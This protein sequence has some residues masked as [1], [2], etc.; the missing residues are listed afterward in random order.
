[1]A[2]LNSFKIYVF[3]HLFIYARLSKTVD[4]F[5]LS[6]QIEFEKSRTDEKKK[7]KKKL[8]NE[9]E[10]NRMKE[11]KELWFLWVLN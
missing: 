5:S 2:F 11:S 1:M 7:K 4:S 9:A 10:I 8:E 3:I 6:F